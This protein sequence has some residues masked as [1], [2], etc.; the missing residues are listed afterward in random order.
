M[1]FPTDMVTDITTQVTSG[2]TLG[3]G[4]GI[5]VLGGLLAWRLFRRVAK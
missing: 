5:L 2:Y 1:S 4:I 3:I